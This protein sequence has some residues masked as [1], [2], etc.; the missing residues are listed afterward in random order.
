MLKQALSKRIA[1]YGEMHSAVANVYW[2]IADILSQE[3]KAEEAKVNWTKACEIY[4]A[5]LG[6]S[7]PTYKQCVDWW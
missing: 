7:H 1:I 3:G 4:K 5:T 6:E 2:N